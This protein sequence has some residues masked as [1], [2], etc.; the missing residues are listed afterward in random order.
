MIPKLLAGIPYT[1]TNPPT[2]SS[3]LPLN[4]SILSGPALVTGSII[5]PTGSGTIVIAADQPGNITYNPAHEVTT[6]FLSITQTQSITPFST[7]GTQTYGVGS[8]TLNA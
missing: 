8:I 5:T 1:I 4:L 6:S 3:G 2:S 7:I